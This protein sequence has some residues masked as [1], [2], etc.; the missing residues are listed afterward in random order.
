MNIIAVIERIREARISESDSM[1]S[2][3]SLKVHALFSGRHSYFSLSSSV[4]IDF[5]LKIF[6]LKIFIFYFIR[7]I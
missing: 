6:A 4:L 3:F 1:V 7:E 5:D 2:K